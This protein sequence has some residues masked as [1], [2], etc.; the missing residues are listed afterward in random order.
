MM[1]PIPMVSPI[2]M[3]DPI[4]VGF[5]PKPWWTPYLWMPYNLCIEQ[6]PLTPVHR[7]IS[8]CFFSYLSRM[9]L[10]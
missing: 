4:S 3:V 2:P 5:N 6:L 8:S 9:G 7:A 10:V 1:D